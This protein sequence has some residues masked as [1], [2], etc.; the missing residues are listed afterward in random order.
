MNAATL[1]K[2]ADLTLQLTIVLREAALE[3]DPTLKQKEKPARERLSTPAY[4]RRLT[5]ILLC[6]DRFPNG[7]FTANHLPHHAPNYGYSSSPSA[8]A[9]LRRTLLEGGP[10]AQDPLIWVDEDGL[11]SLTDKAWGLIK[12]AQRNGYC[13]EPKTEWVRADGMNEPVEVAVV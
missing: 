3:L 6:I 13:W 2:L 9:S 7:G 12:K 10:K 5:G 11:W 4:H 1:T 8:I